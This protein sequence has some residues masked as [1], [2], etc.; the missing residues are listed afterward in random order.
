MCGKVLFQILDV[1][2]M[3]VALVVMSHRSNSN[4]DSLTSRLA[5]S[6]DNAPDQ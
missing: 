5:S 4:A 6:C 1:A 2:R 3:V